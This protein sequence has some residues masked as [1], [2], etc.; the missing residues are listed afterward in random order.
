MRVD[1]LKYFESD[2]RG[3]DDDMIDFR[4]QDK[5]TQYDDEF[6]CDELVDGQVDPV[7]LL[8]RGFMKL[9]QLR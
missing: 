4:L 5:K 8:R 2:F 7:S 3:G 9:A 6:Q 1:K